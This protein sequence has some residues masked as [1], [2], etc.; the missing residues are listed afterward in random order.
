[1][2][3]EKILKV[4]N[5]DKLPLGY[6]GKAI[7]NKQLCYYEYGQL[8]REDGAAF[9]DGPTEEEASIWHWYF[10]GMLHREDGPAI[11]DFRGCTTYF[12]FGTLMLEE[13][14]WQ[15]QYKKY[16][17]DKVKGLFFASKLLGKK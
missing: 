8:H 10:R 14:F 2:A 4:K 1:M 9:F 12:L 17:N 5:R 6:T 13:D 11:E 16:R 7:A 15:F 3:K